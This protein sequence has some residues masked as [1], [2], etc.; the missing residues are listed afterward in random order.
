MKLKKVLK[1]LDF[2]SQI[3]VF[4]FNPKYQSEEEH[5]CGHPLDCPYWIANLH[6]DDTN[7]WDA[8]TLIKKDADGKLLKDPYLEFWVKEK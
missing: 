4:S 5:F 8:I 6:L 7:D 1:H 2:L 3:K